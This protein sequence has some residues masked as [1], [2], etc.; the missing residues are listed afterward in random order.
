[1]S[2]WMFT[3]PQSGVVGALVTRLLSDGDDV[4]ELVP[5]DSAGSPPSR[6]GA[7][8]T[9]AISIGDIGDPRDAD[10]AV[11]EVVEMF[12]GL[13][14]LVNGP[15]PRADPPAGGATTLHVNPFGIVNMT[16]AAA[17]VF[18]A[19]NSGRVF[20]MHTAPTLLG[21]HRAHDD[22]KP[23]LFSCTMLGEGLR[24][25]LEPSADLTVV[26]TYMLDKPERGSWHAAAEALHRAARCGRP[27]ANLEIR[28]DLTLCG[29]P[30]TISE[31]L[32]PSGSFDSGV[33]CC[34]QKSLR[35]NLSA[36]AKVH[37]HCPKEPP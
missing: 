11:E 12:G 21:D 14:F 36:P 26:Q 25:L 10:R 15:A 33:R 18:R 19:Q 37:R 4:V 29:A 9:A 32:P 16:R 2:V 28:P 1:M 27:P 17:H 13:D 5:R 20:N 22:R 7:R 30:T 8:R 6:A 34:G 35:Y 3:G 31:Q 24:A 23:A